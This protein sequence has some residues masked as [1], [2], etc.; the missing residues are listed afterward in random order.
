MD[1]KQLF[2]VKAQQN[3]QLYLSTKRV[4][5]SDDGPPIQ[6]MNMLETGEKLIMRYTNESIIKWV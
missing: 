2:A 5:A 6:T 1:N 4:M 3:H